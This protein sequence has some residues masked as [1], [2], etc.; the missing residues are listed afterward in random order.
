MLIIAYYIFYYSYFVLTAEQIHLQGYNPWGRGGAGAP[1]RDQFGN[2]A[3]D[4]SVR[5]VYIS[6]IDCNNISFAV[7]PN[8][9]SLKDAAYR[10]K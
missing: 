1:I 3:N 2:V 8:K 6:L 9:L 4:Y 10:A 5:K 7:D